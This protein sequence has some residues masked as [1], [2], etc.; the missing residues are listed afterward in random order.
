MSFASVTVLGMHM[1][2]ACSLLL[3]M[4]VVLDERVVGW[5]LSGSG[6]CGI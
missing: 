3:L 4:L 6:I 2:P 5:N 1:L